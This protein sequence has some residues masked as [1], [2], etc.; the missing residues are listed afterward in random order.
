MSVQPI[1]LHL[2]ILAIG[3]MKLYRYLSGCKDAQPASSTG[4]RKSTDSYTF[5]N[6]KLRM[7]HPPHHTKYT[8]RW[9]PSSAVVH[10]MLLR[11][12]EAALVRA[13][14][15][16]LA[17]KAPLH[18]VFPSSV[19]VP[20]YGRSKLSTLRCRDKIVKATS[21]LVTFFGFFQIIN[22]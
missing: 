7:L 2:N 10:H 12:S 18:R 5:W 16:P 21:I 1:T 22:L 15:V 20:L 4:K 6:K 14:C 3:H 11:D 19:N 8:D 13:W 9:A 17:C